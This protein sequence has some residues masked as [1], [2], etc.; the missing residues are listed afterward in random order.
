MSER[1]PAD[2][3]VHEL[4]RMVWSKR[5]WIADFGSGRNQ[6]PQHEIDN[7]TREAEVLEQAVADYR[8]MARRR[9]G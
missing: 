7:K 6:R 1:I 2:Q 4:E 8:T 5:T 3:M 9:T